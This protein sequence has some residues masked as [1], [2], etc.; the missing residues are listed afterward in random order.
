[1]SLGVVYFF[2]LLK[3]DLEEGVARYPFWFFQL[4]LDFVQVA[5]HPV[6]CDSYSK[7]SLSDF[8]EKEKYFFY[9]RKCNGLTTSPSQV[10]AMKY[11]CF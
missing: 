9:L 6:F 7:A 2:V 3:L 4:I 1:M 8:F 10:F 11:P 5:N